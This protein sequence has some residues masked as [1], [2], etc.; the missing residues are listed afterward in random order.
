[1]PR[2]LRYLLVGVVP[3]L[4]FGLI[5]ADELVGN[6]EPT[7]PEQGLSAE[8]QEL[9][10]LEAEVARAVAELRARAAG[11][12]GLRDDLVA[13]G[14]LNRPLLDR[15][16][17]LRGAV[18]GAPPEVVARPVPADLSEGSDL[19]DLEAAIGAKLR[20]VRDSAAGAAGLRDALVAFG[21][22]NAELLGWRRR[23]AAAQPPAAARRGAAAGETAD[24]ARLRAIED[25]VAAALFELR[26][27]AGGAAELRDLMVGFDRSNR[28]LLD[29]RRRLEGRIREAR[30]AT[31]TGSADAPD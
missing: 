26:G 6:E 13:F 24:E 19:A 5:L 10:E 20:L 1:M 30:Q 12:A 11:P 28:D 17:E 7:T 31:L 16:E 22:G 27:R 14:R 4:C 23:A 2:V 18:A 29:E 3:A 25:D 15:I 21:A 8:Q 9:R